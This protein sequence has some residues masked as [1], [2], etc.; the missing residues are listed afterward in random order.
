MLHTRV[1]ST[2]D[3]ED[4][5]GPSKVRVHAPHMCGVCEDTLACAPH[6]VDAR[7][8]GLVDTA[9]LG[10]GGAHQ[11]HPGAQALCLCS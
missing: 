11:A 7:A 8:D 3:C 6:C 2:L 10:R 4:L 5:L 9:Q 1:E